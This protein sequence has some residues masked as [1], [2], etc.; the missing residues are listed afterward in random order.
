MAT[1]RDTLSDN[2]HKQQRN[3]KTYDGLVVLSA[4]P[5]LLDYHTDSGFDF[6]EV[7]YLRCNVCAILPAS[8]PDAAVSYR[9]GLTTAPEKEQDA[10][11]RDYWD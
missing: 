11:R 4:L 1:G 5:I 2:P 7:R 6:L 9:I 10:A 3:T 8:V